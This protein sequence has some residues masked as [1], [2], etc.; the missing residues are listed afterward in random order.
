MGLSLALVPCRQSRWGAGR[1]LAWKTRIFVLSSFNCNCAASRH[2]R[3]QCRSPDWVW[4]LQGHQHLKPLTHIKS[5][6]HKRID[7]RRLH[8]D[9]LCPKAVLCTMCTVV[10]QVRNLEG[11]RKSIDDWLIAN[12][13]RIQTVSS[14]LNTMWITHK[15]FLVSQNSCT[16]CGEGSDGQ[17]Y[18]TQQTSRASKGLRSPH[19]Q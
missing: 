13:Q 10:V 2:W 17:L 19:H 15:P 3:Y 7:R 5:V 16:A 12:D 9:A 4:F 1:C 18:Q 11:S 8:D 14:L 6:C